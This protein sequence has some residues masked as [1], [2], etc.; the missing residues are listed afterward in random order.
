MRCTARE[1]RQLCPPLSIYIPLARER[2]VP[3]RYTRRWTRGSG[4]FAKR[5]SGSQKINPQSILATQSSRD[6]QLFCVENPYVKSISTRRRENS[7]LLSFYRNNP[8]HFLWGTPRPGSNGRA[9]AAPLIPLFFR[10]L[11]ATAVRR[12]PCACGD[13]IEGATQAKA[14]PELHWLLVRRRV[15]ALTRSV[16]ACRRFGHQFAACSAPSLRGGLERWLH[17]R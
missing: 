6:V 12:P 4:Y 11:A 3:R 9:L 17:Q 13:V 8:G 15:Q 5:L 1:I 10:L 14:W 16:R 7:K 2:S